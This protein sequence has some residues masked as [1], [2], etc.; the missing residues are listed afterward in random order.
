MEMVAT[1]DATANI[2]TTASSNGVEGEN[3]GF[4]AISTESN[5]NILLSVGHSWQIIAQWHDPTNGYAKGSQSRTQL[6]RHD[7]RRACGR[8]STRPRNS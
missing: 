7:A 5:N 8:C 2:R 3:L 4:T 6:Y 1:C